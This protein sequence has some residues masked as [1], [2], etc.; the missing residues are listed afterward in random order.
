M[1]IDYKKKQ[2]QSLLNTFKWSIKKA[3]EKGDNVS[4]TTNEIK[5]IAEDAWFCL[6]E[7]GFLE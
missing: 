5:Q 2:N 6:F 1:V 7:E 4:F 3:Y